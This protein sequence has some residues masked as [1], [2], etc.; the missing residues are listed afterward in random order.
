MSRHS[1]GK[2]TGKRIRELEKN[3]KELVRIACYGDPERCEILYG[4]TPADARR[5]ISIILEIKLC[6]DWI[7]SD[8]FA[9]ME[10]VI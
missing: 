7:K 5:W 6:P 10:N 3:Y 4:V 9:H 8:W 1:K 2:R